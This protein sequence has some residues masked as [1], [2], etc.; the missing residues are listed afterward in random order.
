MK[1]KSSRKTKVNFVLKGN[2]FE[3]INENEC[4]DNHKCAKNAYWKAL[5]FCG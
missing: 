5:D 2:G 1:S 3:C 4:E